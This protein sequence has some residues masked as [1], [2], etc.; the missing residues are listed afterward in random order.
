MLLRREE[1]KNRISFCLSWMQSGKRALLCQIRVI[2]GNPVWVLGG[3]ECCKDKHTTP[4]I[5]RGLQG[6]PH[7]QGDWLSWSLEGCET[8]ASGL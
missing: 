7:W 2:K 1:R 3:K 4:D 8:T 6:G 5:A